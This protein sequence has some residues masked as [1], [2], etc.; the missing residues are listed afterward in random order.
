MPIEITM[1]ALSPT[2]T[3]GTLTKWLKKEGDKVSA[4][5]V[6]AEIETD[7]AT[8]EVEAV[9]EGVIGKLLVKA[10]TKNVKVNEV[11]ALLLEE[12][13]D[14]KSL[15]AYEEKLKSQDKAKNKE[16][17]QKKS[18]NS[19][20]NESAGVVSNNN[21]TNNVGNPSWLTSP[22]VV[23]VNVRK[24]VKTLEGT[25]MTKASPLAKTI[26]KQSGLNLS[27]MVGTGP[28]GR[29]TKDDVNEAIRTGI[30]SGRGGKIERNLDE[31]IAIE[32]SSIRQ[33]IATRLLQSKQHIPH[34]YLSIECNIDKLLSLRS[35]LNAYAPVIDEKP[36]YKIS[37][38]DM[39]IKASAL[40]L[41]NVPEVNGS[42]TQDAT[43]RYTNVDISVAVATDTGLITPIVKN[44]DQKSLPAISIEMKELAKKAKNNS[45]K[46]EEFQGGG[47]S[48]S[49]LG[50][51]GIQ[52][53]KAIINPPQSCIMAVGAAN[54]KP[55][56]IDGDIGVA[57]IMNIS[58]SC[59]HRVVDGAVGARFL[60]EFK[61]FIEAP[62]GL[63]L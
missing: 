33:V 34:F 58:L 48:I 40:A 56:I 28:D 16:N 30:T 18:L 14:K 47:F 57:M 15:A 45:L 17:E 4:G 1:P 31:Q 55:I 52:E 24:T 44:A 59:D 63:I 51:Y 50:M 27:R 49:N 29:I 26:A 60:A 46:P 7:K 32:N 62:I 13:E 61:R 21:V 9:D 3:D 20:K 2:M 42:W 38:N 23:N 10:G 11:I 39:I 53:F 22:P 25:S 41:K 54:E 43:I 8:M 36:T 35:E 5:Q 6:I 37:V 12:G 19:A